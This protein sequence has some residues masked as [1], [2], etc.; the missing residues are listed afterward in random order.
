[1]VPPA[2]VRKRAPNSRGTMGKHYLGYLGDAVWELMVL[3]QQYRQVARSPMTVSQ[4][5]RNQMQAQAARLLFRGNVL[6]DEEKKTLKWGITNAFRKKAE[7]NAAGME[8]VG[9]E[10]FSAA[11][12]LRTLL[13]FMWVDASSSDAR[14]HAVARQLGFVNQPGHE[15]ALLSQITNGIYQ[16]S[17]TPALYFMAL[18]PLGHVALRLY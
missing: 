4:T 13:G 10:V 18:A 16:P 1:M 7:M 15:D 6:T 2:E 9:Y 3:V 5:V 14:L 12:G 11:S 17:R 8:E